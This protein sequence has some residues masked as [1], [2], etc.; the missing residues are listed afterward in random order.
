MMNDEHNESVNN[1]HDVY[2][3]G[4]ASNPNIDHVYEP[5]KQQQQQQYYYH[6]NG[7]P[8]YREYNNT[9]VK[10][11]RRT[12][13]PAFVLVISIL[14]SV[15][16][17]SLMGFFTSYSFSH[18]RSSLPNTVEEPALPDGSVETPAELPAE[19]NIQETPEVQPL[20][21]ASDRD[22][23]TALSTVE[24]VEKVADAV[25][26][27]VT[28]SVSTSPYLQQYVT[29]GA[30]SGV[31]VREDGYIITCNHVINGARK[32]TVTLRNGESYPATILASDRVGDIAILKIDADNLTAAPIG[33]S[34]QL[35]VGEDAIVI[36]N[37][38][39]QLG[40][41]VTTGIIS[42]L[43]RVITIDNQEMTLLQTNASINPGNSGG[44]LFDTYG[45]LIG[46]IVAKSAG[47]QVEGIGFAIPSNTV[48]YIYNELMENGY[49]TGRPMLGILMSEKT[50]ITANNEQRTYV[51][52]SGVYDNYPA[53]EAGIEVGDIILSIDG[54][55]IESAAQLKKYIQDKAVG[56]TVT[57]V[58]FRNNQTRTISAV[59]SEIQPEG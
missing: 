26:E 28:E 5:I 4:V 55:E 15:L 7:A 52:V 8:Q 51:V 30:G 58:V 47:T 34:D 27:I 37:P 48:K 13:I 1:N 53:Q 41:S 38:L 12:S 36:G 40:G 6:T 46:I 21:E 19:Q 54:V 23:M 25:V 59:L 32:I 10:R 56:D 33:D 50:G 18:F 42:A 43:E 3:N 22:D 2:Q 9:Q 17:G 57:I 49:V 11:R 14:A 31:I 24:V 29:E 39:G 16:L 20:P 44:G 45:N 35:K